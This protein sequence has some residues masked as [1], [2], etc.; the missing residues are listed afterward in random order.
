MNLKF[1]LLRVGWHYKKNFSSY[2]PFST[3]GFIPAL[4]T[5]P[6]SEVLTS[7]Y[8]KLY[9]CDSTYDQLL[10]EIIAFSKL[11]WNNAEFCR[12]F[13]IKLKVSQRVEIIL[14][15][16]RARKIQNLPKQYR[17]YM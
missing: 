13:P 4:N 15:E 17:F 11:D 16:A 3:R 6:G 10:T 14:A 5:Y 12:K 8:I 7:L 9:D 2:P 1:Y